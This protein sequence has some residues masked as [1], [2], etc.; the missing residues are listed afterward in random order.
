[1]TSGGAGAWRS[2]GRREAMPK[3]R[4]P[5]LAG[6]GVHQNIRRLDVLMD[7]AALVNL[8]KRRGDADGEAQKRHNL[9]GLPEEP[10]QR[11]AAGVLDQERKPPLVR[12]QSQGPGGPGRIE[13]LS[14]R[15]RAA[16]AR[17]FRVRAA[18]MRAWPGGAETVRR[19]AR[20]GTGRSPHPPKGSLAHVLTK[21]S[22]REPLG[23]RHPRT[24]FGQK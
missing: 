7:E 24:S 6:Y 4:K 12:L 15:R 19:P 11:L 3:A 23:R 9:Q 21:S 16:V 22:R 1:M 17:G 2:R 8:G 5:R 14:Q 13:L 18:P 20:P 10:Q